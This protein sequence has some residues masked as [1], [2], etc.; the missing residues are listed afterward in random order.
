ME[1][2]DRYINEL[3]TLPPAPQVLSQLLA[4]LNGKE[5]HTDR[6]IEL[7]AL[8]PALTAKVLQRCNSAASGLSY[9][10][11]G[12]E[13][14]VTRLGFDAIYQMV[15]LVVGEGMLAAE[16]KGYGLGPGD[17]WEHSV[18]TAVAARVLAR[19][20]N[21]NENLAFTAGLLHDIGKLVLGTFL[22]K[23]RQ[24]VPA[25]TGT[26]RNALLETEKAVL[27]ADHAEVG[28][29]LLTRW[30][31]PPSLVR[32]IRFHHNPARARPDELLAAY[33]HFGNIFAHCLGQAK[34]FDA[35]VGEVQPEVFKIVGLRRADVE[36]LLA[37]T[38][39]SLKQCLGVLPTA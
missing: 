19:N 35:F 39:S 18:T 17:L 7:I 5:V 11:S 16:Q 8:D 3:R 2:L 6:I 32:A 9:S 26:G 37:E 1:N 10:V 20:F 27:G 15:T 28:G 14:G 24:E 4:Q 38:E 34:G 13:E 31:F 22:E 23:A 36:A 29:R 33:V 30:S 12:L 25:K 21:G